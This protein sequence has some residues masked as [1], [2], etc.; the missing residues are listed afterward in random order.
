[1]VCRPL[2]N[3]HERVRDE[4]IIL[5]NNTYVEVFKSID[6]KALCIGC[7]FDP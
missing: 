7:V 3:I 2:S 6:T 4:R 1:M 5:S